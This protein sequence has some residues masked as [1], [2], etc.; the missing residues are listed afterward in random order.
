M[1]IL[2]ATDR[3]VVVIDVE[4]GAGAP[5]HG[6]GGRPTCL[7]ADPL[8]HGRAWCGTHRNG[9]FR[10]DDGG[11]SWQ[12]VGLAGR[13]IMAVTA[14][15]ADRDVVWVGTEPSEVWRSGDAG[16]TWE[17]TSK[18]ETLSSSSEWSFPPRPDTHHV[19]W[20]ACHP[21]EPERLW[22]AI[23]A[24]ALVSTM[25][26]GRT[27]SDRVPGGPRDTH[28]LVIHHKAS[29][30]LCVSAGDGYFESDDAGATWRSP[31]DGLEVG[32]LRSVT[33]DAEQPEVVVVS[34]SSGP[35]SAYVAGRSDGRLY[36]RLTRERWERVRDGWPE[37]ASTIAPLLCTGAKGG[38][39]WAADE[40]GVHCSDDGGKSWRRAV[41][42]AT[43]P[44]YLRG[45]ALVQ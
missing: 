7:T 25:D 32:Y 3:E 22:V 13:L 45:L 27:W 6:I 29:D 44:Q 43:S 12:S 28:E 10:T 39:L 20:I 8:V 18:L 37:P 24:G 9:V 26:G 21:L 36:R 33:I 2:V 4:R 31:T 41:G 30:T 19:R 35:Y 16:N 40:R 38:E 1:L 15:P 14:S 11:R 34:A 23:E 5:V 17:Q 42:Y